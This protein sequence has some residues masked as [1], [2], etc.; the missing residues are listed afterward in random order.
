LCGARGTRRPSASAIVARSVGI[1]VSA[2]GCRHR[3]AG[4]RFSRSAPGQ[5]TAEESASQACCELIGG[6]LLRPEM[7]GQRQQGLPTFEWVDGRSPRTGTLAA[8]PSAAADSSV[9]GNHPKQRILLRRLPPLRD[10]RASVW[11]FGRRVSRPSGTP[12]CSRATG[13]APSPRGDCTLWPA[14]PAH[15]RTAPRSHQ[16]RPQAPHVEGAIHRRVHR[17]G[18]EPQAW[19]RT[20]DSMP[21]RRRQRL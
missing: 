4:R 13:L 12:R 3:G 7:G 15:E 2:S 19:P 9:G 1:G 6:Y 11:R 21:C 17:A 14:L 16:R 10:H 5:A 8:S 20:T 18:P